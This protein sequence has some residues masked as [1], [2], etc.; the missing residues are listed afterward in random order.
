MSTSWGFYNPVQIHFGLGKVKKLPSFVGNDSSKLIVTTSGHVSR[1]GVGGLEEQLGLKDYF[2][3]DKVVP[4]PDIE[5]ILRCVDEFSDEKISSVVS[6]GGGSVIDTG[7]TVALMLANKNA[8]LRD[9]LVDA[10]HV[11][12]LPHFAIPTTS[13]T[14]AEVTPFATIWDQKNKK[15]HS[16]S[17]V[18]VYPAMAVLDPKLTQFLP[19][20]ETV[21]TALDTISHALE[22]LWNIGRTPIT[23]S[24]ACK[25][26]RSSLSALPEVLRE[27][28]CIKSRT[29]LMEASLL[30]GMAISQTKTAMAHSIS[31]PLTSYFGVPHGLACSFSLSRIITLY[32]TQNKSDHVVP[33]MIDVQSLLDS[34]GLQTMLGR[35]VNQRD[36]DE[37]KCKMFNPSRAGNFTVKDFEIKDLVDFEL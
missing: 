36:L 9:L 10:S 7:K 2:V 30:A 8:E 26:L 37:L 15:K 13:G 19:E 6:I 11:K 4:N 25:S 5:S 22:S 29:K 1:A 20:K 28:G 12:S 14:G 27:P 35:Y 32:A 3:F 33:L 17:G 24:F 31:Y 34:L 23:E 21:I 16:L 18:S